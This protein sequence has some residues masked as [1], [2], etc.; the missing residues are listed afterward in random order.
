MAFPQTPIDLLAEM[1]IGGVWTDITADLYARGLLTIERG[2]PDEATTV[3]P[4]KAA[5][6][7]NNRS[8]QYSPRNPRSVNHGLIGRNTPVR[9]SLAGPQSY[10]A[11]TGL[12]ADIISTP[13]HASLDITGDIELR[14]EASLEDWFVT[15]PQ[16]LLGKWSATAGQRSYRLSVQ[17][18]Y[19]QLLWTTAGTT[20][21]LAQTLLPSEMPR[22]AALRA[23]LDVNNGAGG[24]SARIYWARSMDGPWTEL[25]G[26]TQLSGTGITSIHSGTAALEIAPTSGTSLPAL[27][28]VHRAEVRNGIG[29][30]VVASPDFRLQP[31]G[32]TSFTDS[33]GR[34]WTAA[35]AAAITNREYRIHGE[36]SSWPPRWD[37]SGKDVYVPVEAAGILRRLGQGKKALSSTLRRRLPS[38]GPPAAYWP[39]ED[40]RDAVQAAS[41]LVG[42]PPMPV[43]GFTFGQDDSCPGS[44]SL[45]AI[46]PAA[47]MQGPVPT[48]VSPTS[49]YLVSFL[50]SIDAPPA[51]DSVMLAITTTGTARGFVLS[52]TPTGFRGA[53]YDAAGA[54]LFNSDYSA[55]PW[56]PGRWFRVDI[57]AKV[58]GS[59][60]QFA[61]LFIEVDGTGGYGDWLF[62]AGTVGNVISID[63]AFGPLLD[64]M[65]FGHL[66]VFPGANLTVWGGSD[67]GY[68]GEIAS[69]RIRRLA[70]EETVPVSTDRADTPLGA[71]RPDTLLGL[72]RQCEAA[73]GGILYEDRER[74]ALRYR[75]RASRYSQPVALTLDYSVD[76]HIA[77]PLEPVDDDQMVRNDR[78]IERTNG[79]SA[80][81]VLETGPLSVQDPPDGVGIYDDSVT[82]NL[83]SDDQTEPIAD[84]LL[85]LGTWDEARY[86]T[87]HIDLAAA[88]SLIPDVLALEI[89]DRIQ[90][91]N[92]PEWLP[93]G[94]IDLI[95]EGYTEVIGHPNDWD[96]ILNCSPAGPWNVAVLDDASLARLGGGASTLVSGINTTATSLSVA[97]ASGPLWTTSAGDLPLTVEIGGETMT[98]TAVSGASSPQT[99][100]VTR[101]ANAVIKSHLAG[102][103]VDTAQP[104]ILAL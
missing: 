34:L 27:G 68:G 12:S 36:V 99:L 18:G 81:A 66:G 30:T 16:L 40:G 6:E 47:V 25:V 42:C 65:R 64:G 55:D 100:T 38:Q 26:G 101:S 29:G 85:H 97:T 22:R 86:P 51:S 93:P 87:V 7:L 43:T 19:A 31:A 103:A 94:P 75:S 2:R 17:Q 10:L 104:M 33:A 83:R 56:G 41:P 67:N 13:D 46:G 96:V 78:T 91:I 3:D 44:D 9:F 79:S 21:V 4:G 73:D 77:P 20:T 24:W 50:Y 14:V 61:A 89:G 80:R 48:Y 72:L 70:A 71:Q 69:D 28:R 57:T 23:S 49:D 37:V 76:G 102:A 95:V 63:T 60:I 11:L 62:P 52:L 82:L 35:G 1:Q 74:T 84:W 59:D 53:A 88:P 5:F 8:G 98:V 90:I 39:F 54:T 45:P 58:V 15:R 32:T 92:P